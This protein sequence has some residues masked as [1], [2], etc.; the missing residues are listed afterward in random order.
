[1]SDTRTVHV[2]LPAARSAIT[3]CLPMLVEH[4][5][6]TA[7]SELDAACEGRAYVPVD[8]RFRAQESFQRGPDE[9]DI[10]FALTVALTDG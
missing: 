1:M 4:A 3:D 2:T 9:F 6:T 7:R 10:E 5:M 8:V